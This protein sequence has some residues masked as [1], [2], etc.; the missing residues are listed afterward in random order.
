LPRRPPRGTPS[1]ALTEEFSTIYFEEF[2]IGLDSWVD[3]IIDAGTDKS[4]TLGSSNIKLNSNPT[5]VEGLNQKS[6]YDMFK[7]TDINGA[8]TGHL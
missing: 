6:S 7:W 5:V 3:A 2:S 1:L 4:V 8:N